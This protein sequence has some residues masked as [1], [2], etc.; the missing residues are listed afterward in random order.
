MAYPRFAVPQLLETILLVED[1]PLVRI[2][3]AE[4]LRES[5]YRVL[6]A[7]DAAE[8]LAV[9]GSGPTI[10][11]VI[12]DVRLPGETDGFA[13]G[14]QIRAEWPEIK[15]IATSGAIRSARDDEI[16]APVLL[17]PYSR[18]DLLDRVQTALHGRSRGAISKSAPR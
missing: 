12:S 13:L 6:E 9:L 4:F 11:L 15:F 2:G 5:G 16:G 7:N 8:A 14:R 18:R 10:E 17:K 1:E 3:L